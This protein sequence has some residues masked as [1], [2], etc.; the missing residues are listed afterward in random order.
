M[1]RPK[2]NPRESVINNSSNVKK[3]EPEWVIPP[4][5]DAYIPKFEAHCHYSGENPITV[6]GPTGVGKRLFLKIFEKIFREKNKNAPIIWVNCA[7]FGGDIN[8]CRSELFGH[9][10]GS[11]TGAIYNHEGYVTKANGG[12]LVLEEIG[13]LHPQ[14][15]ALLLDFID[16]GRYN[17]VGD[18]NEKKASVRIIGSTND[19][20]NLQ[21]DF[22]FRCRPFNVPPI[23]QRRDDVFYYI[24]FKYPNLIESL[25][26]CETLTLLAYNW[27]GN[28]REIYRVCDSIICTKSLGISSISVPKMGMST[29]GKSLW[30]LDEKETG[31]NLSLAISLHDKLQKGKVDVKL[32]ESILNSRRVG[33]TSSDRAFPDI[34][35]WYESYSGDEDYLKPPFIDWSKIDDEAMEKIAAKWSQCTEDHERRFNIKAF[36][37]LPPFWEAYAGYLIFCSLFFQNERRNENNLSID[38]NALQSSGK[39][40]GR[41]LINSQAAT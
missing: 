31:L 26:R 24:Y 36:I 27:P 40:L 25:T 22:R 7:S 16:T 11:S 4:G 37:P 32:L 15:Q 3:D 20:G 13:R 2:V 29:F 30:S 10:K 14:A 35:K 1:Q 5:L 34:Q 19:E 8:L 23:C 12:V 39:S 9:K 17:I 21:E 6:V 38:K 28:V 41:S 33:L 18:P